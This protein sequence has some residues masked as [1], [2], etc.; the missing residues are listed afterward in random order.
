MNEVMN[1]LLETAGNYFGEGRNHEGQ[2]FR[3]SFE[4]KPL[5]EGRVLELR[6]RAEG[7]NGELFH[8]ESSLIS[9]DLSGQ[10]NL[11]VTSSNH[12]GLTVHRFDR[13]ES[14][15]EGEKR[16]I[17]RF[18]NPEDKNTF[19]EEITIATYQDGS[20]EHHYSWGMP[21][22]EFEPRSGSKMKKILEN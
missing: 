7:L 9:S 14:G 10:L 15:Q 6:S 18:G 22:G 8:E 16:I 20:V 21:G 12:P 17:F 19:R 13:L 4:L 11:Y 3:G 2:R 1:L 5:F